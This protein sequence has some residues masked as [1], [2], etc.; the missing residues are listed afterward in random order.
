MLNTHYYCNRFSNCKLKYE[1]PHFG[2]LYPGHTDCNLKGRCVDV[3]EATIMF[4]FYFLTCLTSLVSPA[5]VSK[6]SSICPWQI[7]SID[8]GDYYWPDNKKK[9]KGL[10]LLLLLLFFKS[11][12]YHF[13]IEALHIQIDRYKNRRLFHHC[14]SHHFGTGHSYIRQYLENK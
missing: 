1:R 13:H 3:H 4:F 8:L 14:M 11:S 5:W 10:L 2:S 6:Y 9:T 7:E 12:T